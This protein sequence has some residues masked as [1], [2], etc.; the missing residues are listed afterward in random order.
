MLCCIRLFFFFKQKTAYE[1]RISDWSSDVCSSDLLVLRRCRGM[2]LRRRRGR[3]RRHQREPAEQQ[4]KAER[5]KASHGGVALLRWTRPG[6]AAR[7]P[8]QQALAAAGRWASS[9]PGSTARTSSMN[10]PWR[11][12]EHRSELQSLIR[13]SY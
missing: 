2:V 11:S 9:A 12:E 8:P 3:N 10:W 4:K 13:I 7:H 1:M 5:E 6:R